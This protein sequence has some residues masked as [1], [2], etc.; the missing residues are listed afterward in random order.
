MRDIEFSPRPVRLD[1]LDAVVKA[2]VHDTVGTQ[3]TQ[4]V[5]VSCREHPRGR[6]ELRIA[7]AVDCPVERA[8]DRPSRLAVEGGAPLVQ[9]D[10]PDAAGRG[11]FGS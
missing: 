1:D 6:A 9:D 8:A 4:E 2:H 11:L 7:W 10:D 5:I 3:L